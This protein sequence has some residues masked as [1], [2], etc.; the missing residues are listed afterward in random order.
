MAAFSRVIPVRPEPLALARTLRDRPFR[1]VLWSADGRG[2]SWLACDPDLCCTALTPP[3]A[4][5][6]CPADLEPVPQWIGYVPYEALRHLER[7]QEGTAGSRERPA[8]HHTTPHWA[9]FR[10][11]ARIDTAVTVLG[12]DADAVDALAEGLQ[13]PTASAGPV[14]LVDRSDALEDGRHA[15]RVRAALERIARGDLYVVNLARLFQFDVLGD[16]LD[17]L[18]HLGSV[19]CAPYCASFEGAG[20]TIVCSSPEL[21]LLSGPGDIVL[22]RPIKGTR[23]R[24]VTPADDYRLAEELRSDPKERAELVMVT[25]IERN[26]LGRIAVAGSVQV[27]DPGS[28]ATYGPVHHRL[29]TVSARRRA[30]VSLRELFEAVLPSGSVTGAPKIKAMECIAQLEGARRGLYTGAHGYI[31]HGGHARLAMSIR[32]LTVQDGT[33]HY[34]AGGGIVADSDP[35]REVAE[36]HWKAAQLRSRPGKEDLPGSAWRQSRPR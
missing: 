31:S 24:G 7:P 4:R 11:V 9:R 33:G 26:D 27:V 36:T 19:S 23:P 1:T 12:D 16:A 25:D 13:R 14:S 30:S 21:L 18:E 8:P 22:T 10:A 34:H 6:S 35:R 5:C 20:P 29:S 32:C 15:E 28:I 17:L 3:E 2:P